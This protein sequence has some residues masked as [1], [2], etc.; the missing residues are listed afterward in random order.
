M[1]REEGVWEAIGLLAAFYGLFV[2]GDV[3]TT[4][5]L[6][7]HF[8]G[9]IS[10]ELNPLA[11]AIYAHY[12]LEGML[13]SKLCVFAASSAAVVGLYIKYGHVKWFRETL[14]TAM[15]CLSGLSAIVMVNNLLGILAVSLCLYGAAPEWLL[16]CLSYA[17]SLTIA[18]LGGYMLLGWRGGAE[19]L[20]GTALAAL[21]LLCWHQLSPERYLTYLASLFTA[22]GAALYLVERSA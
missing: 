11:R 22:V 17:L 1:R 19:A 12:G 3:A 14:E 21:P 20:V 7:K 4:F 13:A 8:P 10:G 15:L 6:V 16:R 5:W 9:G 2:V 18:A